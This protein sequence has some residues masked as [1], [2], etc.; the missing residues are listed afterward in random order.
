MERNAVLR[1]GK[2]QIEILDLARL[3]HLAAG[4]A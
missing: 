4:G 1:L 2:A 3:Q